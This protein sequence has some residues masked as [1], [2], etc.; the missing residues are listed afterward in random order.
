[1]AAQEQQDER[2]V[3]LEDGGLVDGGR[4]PGGIALLGD[5][6]AVRARSLAAPLVDEPAL[7]RAEQPAIRLRRDALA[8]PVV[9]GREERLLDRVLRRVEVA[10]TA[11][12]RAED[13]R[14]KVA[15]QVLDAGLGGAGL[16]QTACPTCSRN[17]PIS[18]AFDGASSMTWR[19][20]I[21]CWVGT[22]FWPGT[23]E[24]RAAISIARASDSTS[25]IW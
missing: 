22:P 11:R 3:V 14:R 21:G 2:V 20:V 5:D 24:S 15:Q 17:A 13:P 16:A 6:L 10:R 18:A 19:T 8:G 9:G 1:M 12:E 23:A 4:L 25:T 7:R